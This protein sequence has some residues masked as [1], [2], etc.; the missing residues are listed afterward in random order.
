MWIPSCLKA[1]TTSAQVE[2]PD[3]SCRI[4]SLAYKER[5]GRCRRK[6]ELH[7]PRLAFWRLAMTTYV[8]TS[9]VQRA[10]QYTV[11]C[12]YTY[13]TQRGVTV[14]GMENCRSGFPT[15]RITIP[16]VWNGKLLSTPHLTFQPGQS[17]FPWCVELEMESLLSIPY[18]QCGIPAQKSWVKAF[19]F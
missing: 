12:R 7:V 13:Y 5:R 2:P 18:F 6:V 8:R 9:Y 16:G 17:G 3:N 15:V 11:R 10:T 19:R 4:R 1:V 14:C